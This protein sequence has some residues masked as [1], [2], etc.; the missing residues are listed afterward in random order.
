MSL[1]GPIV[2]ARTHP[3]EFLAVA[4]HVAQIAVAE[5]AGVQPE[6]IAIRVYRR[7][8]QTDRVTE[9]DMYRG[10]LHIGGA[11]QAVGYG[12]GATARYNAHG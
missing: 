3:A 12:V 10:G 1:T 9:D 11:V 6:Q 5:H 7:D 2:S 4:Y 8:V